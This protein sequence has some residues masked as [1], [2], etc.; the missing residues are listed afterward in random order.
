MSND[1]ARVLIA[2]D[3]Y[4]NR[5]ILSS[6]LAS[7][8]VEAD[9]A[10]N[11]KECLALC[12]EN[13]YDMIF[14]DQKM[15]EQSGTDTLLQLNELFQEK[16]R[17]IPVICHTAEDSPKLTESYRA[18]GYADVLGKPAQPKLLT[19]LLA[20]YLPEGSWSY[21]TDPAEAA[22]HLE[23]ELTLLP[24]WLKDCKELDPKT[25]IMHCQT[26]KDYLDALT[27]FIRSISDKAEEIKQA[28]E[29]EYWKQ[30]TLHVHSLKSIS[31]L[32]GANALHDLAATLENAGEQ[33]DTDRIRQDAPGLLEQCLAFSALLTH[34]S[35]G[36]EPSENPDASSGLSGLIDNPNAETRTSG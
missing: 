11:G 7:Y 26:A 19:A 21:H 16:G 8:G 9:E 15:P 33:T 4:I 32:V 12:R 25:G 31:K 17:E 10:E 23:H 20:N 36:A 5:M 35:Q 6:L 24:D 13:S 30:Y 34:I 14:L 1:V 2:D 18:A 22:A 29:K 28:L 3:A 27:V